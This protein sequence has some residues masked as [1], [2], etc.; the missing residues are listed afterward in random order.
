MRKI[1]GKTVVE[2]IREHVFTID[3]KQTKYEICLKLEQESIIKPTIFQ[4]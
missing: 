2:A 4:Q 3:L 1:K